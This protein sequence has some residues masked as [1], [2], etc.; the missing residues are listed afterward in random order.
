MSEAT[1]ND[2]VK[3]VEDLPPLK[4]IEIEAPKKTED[5]FNF[6]VNLVAHKEKGTGFFKSAI[7]KPEGSGYGAFEIKCDEG[8]LIGGTDLAPAPLSYLGSGVAFCFLSHVYMYEQSRKLDITSVKVEQKMR[9]MLA[10]NLTDSHDEDVGHGRC[11]GIDFNVI[12]ESPEPKEEIEKMIE[13]CT[14]G[15]IGLQT[16]INATPPSFKLIHNP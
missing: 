13:V 2:L 12:V 4:T 16:V 5:G 3:K 11:Y 1:Q 15:C 14:T 6:E 10:S 9:F 7:A 8:T